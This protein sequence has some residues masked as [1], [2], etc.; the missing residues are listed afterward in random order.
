MDQKP[1]T[2][3]D[4][5]PP[6]PARPAATPGQI[7]PVAVKAA[8][9]SAPLPSRLP[10]PVVTL[11]RQAVSPQSMAQTQVMPKPKK[12]RRWLR[13]LIG[14][15]VFLMVAGAAFAWYYFIYRTP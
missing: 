14:L 3:N 5:R 10:E 7:R 1:R 6:Q 11:T 2:T 12:H 8:P 4:I 15:I 9:S 13:V